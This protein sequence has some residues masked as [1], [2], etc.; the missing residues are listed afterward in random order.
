MADVY[1]HVFE[2]WDDSSIEGE[3]PLHHCEIR[4]RLIGKQLKSLVSA[5][6]TTAFE[7]HDYWAGV[8]VPVLHPSLSL[9]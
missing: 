5:Q 3:C 1:L 2:L 6:L 8:I 4:P 9:H 7:C